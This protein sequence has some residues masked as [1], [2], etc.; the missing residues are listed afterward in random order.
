MN[1]LADFKSNNCPLQPKPTAL[2]FC[3]Q[4]SVLFDLNYHKCILNYPAITS[5]KIINQQNA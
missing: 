2:V 1:I 4:Y 5:V 3:V